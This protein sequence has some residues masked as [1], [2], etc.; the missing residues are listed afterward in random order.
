MDKFDG[1][2]KV[3]ANC[4]SVECAR[5][6]KHTTAIIKAMAAVAIVGAMLIIRFCG[7]GAAQSASKRVFFCDVFGRE[8]FGLGR[9]FDAE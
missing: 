4:R 2:N 9:L 3:N 8:S 1:C 6:V 5:K 7:F